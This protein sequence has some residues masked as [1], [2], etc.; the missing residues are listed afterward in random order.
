MFLFSRELWIYIVLSLLFIIIGVS[1]TIDAANRNLIIITSWI[2]SMVSLVFIAYN[3][4]LRYS[5]LGLWLYVLLLVVGTVWLVDVAN[6]NIF[7]FIASI[8]MIIC[9]IVLIDLGEHINLITALLYM[10]IWSAFAI[11]TTMRC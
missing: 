6:A 1:V 11:Y 9:G 10:I 3:A 2:I 8:I 5:C 7:V 4:S